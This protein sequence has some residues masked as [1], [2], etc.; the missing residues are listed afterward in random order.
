MRKGVG[1]LKY[2]F[3][4]VVIDLISIPFIIFFFSIFLPL[5]RIV[6]YWRRRKGMKFRILWGPTPILTIST[7]SK[8]ERLF[9]YDSKTLVYSTYYMTDNFD[10]NLERFFVV[11]IFRV[12]MPWLV[13]LWA[14]IKYDVFH[15]FFDRGFLPNKAPRGI[16]RFELPL[17]K[18]AG[19]IVI[20]SAYGGDVRYETKCRSGGKYHC[21]TD[22]NQRLKA[23][24]CSE[25]LAFSNVKYVNRY[26]DLTL[27]MGDMKAYTPGSRNDVFYWAIDLAGVDYV[28]VRPGNVFPIKIVH[29]PNHRQ[30]KGTKYLIETV[31]RIKRQGYQ[32]DLQLIEKILNK[33]AIHLYKEAD[34]IAEQFLIG[35]HGYLAVEGMA[36]GKP[37]V[38]FI[39]NAKEDYPFDKD[40]PIVSADPDTL[41]KTLLWLIQNPEVRVELGKNGRTY[42]EE[43][44]SLESVG[45]RLDKI[46]QSL[47][48]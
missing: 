9:G 28:G 17:L 41:E 8:A 1:N 5:S 14:V 23:C 4:Q 34:I 2:A 27:S 24:I 48:R 46:Y 20:V 18:L 36:L 30:F 35:W 19:K 11:P 22:C 10:Y 43:V 38:C 29:A 45:K 25:K 37:V 31:D 26:A 3:R 39:R 21:C 15:F 13:F 47:R 42:A 16:N 40:C 33:D 6:R 44:F 32:V 12:W 7:N